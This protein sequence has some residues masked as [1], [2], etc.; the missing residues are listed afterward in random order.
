MGESAK[1]GVKPF[2]NTLIKKL[3]LKGRIRIANRWALKNPKFLMISFLISMAAIF[4]MDYVIGN[5]ISDNKNENVY[6]NLIRDPLVS[7]Y[8]EIENKREE[9][10]MHLSLLIEQGNRL[11]NSLDSLNKIETKTQKD[12][13]MMINIISRL[14]T[15]SNILSDEKN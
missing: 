15:I 7:S 8:S 12:S 9:M 3:R 2:G 5:L 11:T 1:E 10:K 13:L 4:L 6:S 14:Q